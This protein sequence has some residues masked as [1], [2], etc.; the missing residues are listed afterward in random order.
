[1]GAVLAQAELAAAALAVGSHPDEELAA[2]REVAIRGSDI[3]RQ[4]MIYAGK[5]SDVVEFIDVSKTVEEMYGLLKSTISKRAA[6]V[7]D[8]SEHLPAVK[9]RTAQ[10]RQVVMNLVGNASDAI[11]DSNGVIRVTTQ[12]VT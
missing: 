9:A 5:E 3:V 4:L 7:T 12:R 8:L 10:L 1:M 11:K 6:L 2:I